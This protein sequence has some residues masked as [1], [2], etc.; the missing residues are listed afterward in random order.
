MNTFL[1]IL[2]QDLISRKVNLARTA[3]VFPNK[4]AALFLDDAIAKIA[5]PPIWSPAY[6]TIS[7]I[8]RSWSKLTVA[9]DIK[10]VIELYK[11]YNEITGNH[12]VATAA[13]NNSSQAMQFDL[14]RF[15]PWGLV[16]LSD[17]DDIDKNLADAQQ[18][19]RNI[20]S[21]HEFD[22][23]KYL[24][25]TQKKL[26]ETFFDN[27]KAEQGESRLKEN[28]LKL[29]NRMADIYTNFRERLRKQGLAYEG[30]LYRDVIDVIKEGLPD[31][32]QQFDL[33]VF[34][35]F[36]V[37]Q[38]VEYQLFK[39][40]KEK[41]EVLFYWDIDK[42]YIGSGNSY[43]T[44]PGFFI[45]QYMQELP[46]AVD[47]D[48]ERYDNLRQP[49]D[50]TFLGAATENLQARYV[51]KWLKETPNGQS[52]PRY[53]DGKKTAIV[54]CDE[55]LLQ[56]VIH[57]IPP[58]A[59]SLNVTTGYP[60]LQSAA[61]SFVIQLLAMQ[62]AGWNTRR[63]SFRQRWKNSVERHPYYKMITNGM[64]EEEKDETDGKLF[65]KKVIDNQDSQQA[66]LQKLA[67]WILLILEQIKTKDPFGAEAIFKIY[68]IVNRL[69]TLID[70]GDLAVSCDTFQRLLKQIISQSSVPF[71]GEPAEGVQI[72]GVLETRCLDFDHLLLLS[73]NDD[74][75]PKG[76]TDNSIIPYNIR[77]AFSLTT[78]EHKVA[79]YA[80]YFNRLLQRAAD[81]SITYNN[82]PTN[83]STGEKSRF[84]LQLLVESG[85]KIK[86]KSLQT[87]L[88]P[89]DPQ[90]PVIEKTDEMVEEIRK[91]YENE[92]YPVSP[93]S[94]GRYLRCPLAY[95]FKYVK[96][97]KETEE[98]DENGFDARHFGN[99]F[100][101]TL[102]RLY[103]SASEHKQKGK[104][105]SKEEIENIR[106]NDALIQ[107]TLDDALRE[108]LEIKEVNKPIEEVL[109]GL[110]LI[111]REV[112]KQ[113]VKNTLLFDSRH[114]PL[115]IHGTEIKMNRKFEIN[116][117][118]KSVP[119]YLG[120]TIDR[121]DEVTIDGQKTMR[122]VDYKTGNYNKNKKVYK[123]EDFF[124]QE[125][126][127]KHCDYYLQTFIYADI[128]EE[129]TNLNPVVPCLL[130][131]QH[132]TDSNYDIRLALKN[133]VPNDNGEPRE[134][135]APVTNIRD[136]REELRSRLNALL[137]EI[138]DKSKPFTPTVK[139]ERCKY[140]GYKQLCNAMSKQ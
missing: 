71:H 74:K 124:D 67:A 73:C 29:W 84:M 123:V 56:T 106:K 80:Y 62:T 3:V 86:Q 131:A 17:F 95:Y 120:G 13:D 118:N 10:L 1:D 108:E 31:T 69:K 11:S 78:T 126:I 134:V 105:L 40:L 115:L 35:G 51:A 64:S 38:K 87:G 12:D 39:T 119:V 68:T 22:T 81:I 48:D 45:K 63:E 52:H 122:I 130:F 93:S 34:A 2:A 136:Y 60:L 42:S 47:I 88:L 98:D 32:T 55:K 101:K 25:D 41:R 99:V 18:V 111:N 59:G 109:V 23:I 72:M 28:F 138:A 121:I 132:A 77:K 140:C 15:F 66:Q 91:N 8:F 137:E 53:K 75:M 27:F 83:G 114:A 76:T 65:F 135:T 49:K 104:P 133:T 79:V 107:Q 58:E 54:M 21:L 113:Y 117:D 96:H 112:L 16:M 37:L 103:K 100:H 43:P 46:N 36:N 85:Q 14:D 6:F 26:L 61:A 139:Q 70:K 92:R 128:F 44:S 125:K 110:Q 20:A 129:N 19:F 97:V 30:M 5:Q 89:A 24:D 94:L 90:P 50:I 4:R 33:I 116:V 102:E 9:D 57:S 82:C 7:D 127:E